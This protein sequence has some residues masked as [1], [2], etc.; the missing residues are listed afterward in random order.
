MRHPV[1]TYRSVE[2]PIRQS[3]LE[4][5][6]LLTT[7]SGIYRGSSQ[8]RQVTQ[9]PHASPP[10]GKLKG[11]GYQRGIQTRSL[12]PVIV[13]RPLPTS[14]L[15]YRLNFPLTELLRG[16]PAPLPHLGGAVEAHLKAL[17]TSCPPFG[18][19]TG[20]FLWRT[21]VTNALNSCQTLNSK[22]R[23]TGCGKTTS[24]CRKPVEI[25]D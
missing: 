11:R 24:N 2:K 5:A 1:L 21:N 8:P 23:V 12:R 19:A 4:F 9:A 13:L 18:L 7:H 20:Q 10:I 15:R 16:F 25:Y 17:L 22:P 6:A 14:P 3:R